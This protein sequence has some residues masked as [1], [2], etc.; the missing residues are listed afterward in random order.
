MQV[1]GAASARLNAALQR[2]AEPGVEL[3][4]QQ[5]VM[6]TAVYFLE[7]AAAAVSDSLVPLSNA[8]PQKA[9]MQPS[10]HLLQ[11]FSDSFENVCRLKGCLPAHSN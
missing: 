4:A 7:C 9:A 8:S 5:Q 11:N 3:A 2:C 1:I 10:E 6:D